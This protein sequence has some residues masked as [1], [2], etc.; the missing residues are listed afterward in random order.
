ML[1]K[2]YLDY[3]KSN[4]VE[5]KLSTGKI[6]IY[7]SKNSQLRAR[8]KADLE[9]TGTRFLKVQ[10]RGQVLQC[11]IVEEEYIFYKFVLRM[12]ITY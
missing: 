3:R 5:V 2:F 8:L 7:F 11:H 1:K 6:R 12:V 9:G 4:S 10:D